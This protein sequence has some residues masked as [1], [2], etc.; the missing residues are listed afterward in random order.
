MTSKS[1]MPSIDTPEFDQALR[2]DQDGSFHRAVETYLA[3]SLASLR[4]ELLRGLSP[5]DFERAQKIEAALLKAGDV[6]RY[7]AQAPSS[8]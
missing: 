7:S 4:T 1:A 6:I 3:D 2:D 8:R 5:I